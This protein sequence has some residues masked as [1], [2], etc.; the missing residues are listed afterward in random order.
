MRNYEELVKRLRE[1]NGWALNET[2]DQAANAIEE[3]SK[4]K[5]I[6]VEGRE[7]ITNADKI[8]AMSDEELAE[9]LWS[10]GQ[11]PFS[12]NVYLNGKLIFFSGDGNGWLDWLKEEND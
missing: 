11:S 10:I 7:K 6:S 9:F 5:W 12:G 2:L 1:H 3:L 8:R 4:P